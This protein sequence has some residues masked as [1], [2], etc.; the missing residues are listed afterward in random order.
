MCTSTWCQP[1]VSLTVTHRMDVDVCTQIV[2]LE[3]VDVTDGFFQYVLDFSRLVVVAVFVVVVLVV[4]ELL[5][6]KPVLSDLV[7]SIFVSITGMNQPN[8]S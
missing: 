6:Y 2:H 5:H 4:D 1:C 8:V 3:T 7:L